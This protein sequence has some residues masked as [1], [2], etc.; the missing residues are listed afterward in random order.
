M[1]TLVASF[2]LMLSRGWRWSLSFLAIQ[3]LGVFFFVQTIWP[4]SLAIVKLISGLI[5]CFSLATSQESKAS[6]S[7]PEISW[8]QGRLFRLLAAGL[9]LIT[10][11]AIAPQAS[12]W[13]GI[14]NPGGTWASLLLMGMG[15]LQLGI[16]TQPMRVIIGLLTLLSGFEILYAFVESSALVS[17]MLVLINLGLPLVGIYLLV[18]EN[19]EKTR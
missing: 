17:A 6:F 1:V 13:L 18:P 14:N 9:I 10:T 4:I 3:Y 15:L 2:G 5:V 19:L 7:N 8:P 12:N 16:T 11:L